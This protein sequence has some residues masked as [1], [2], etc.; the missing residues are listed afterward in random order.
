M[1]FNDTSPYRG[2]NHSPYRAQAGATS[3]ILMFSA[4]ALVGAA[5]ALILTPASGREA[6]QYLG[7]RGK[8]LADNVADQGKKLAENVAQE[9]RRMWNEHGGR[10]TRAM[11]DG[12]AHASE[13]IAGRS[14]G[15]G[16]TGNPV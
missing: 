11:R 1:N 7:R 10:V 14:N 5:A 2:E 8:D 12:Y 3:A 9:G 16:E 13:Q 4:G 6:R 15:T